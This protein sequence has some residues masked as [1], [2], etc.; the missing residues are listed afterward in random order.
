MNTGKVELILNKD[1]DLNKIKCRHGPTLLLRSENEEFLACSACRD[2][3]DCDM[4]IPLEKRTHK[5]T[6][7]MR[8]QHQREYKNFRKFLRTLDKNRKENLRKQNT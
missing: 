1:P 6:K 5:S 2:R 7:S 3:R 8:Q 4:F